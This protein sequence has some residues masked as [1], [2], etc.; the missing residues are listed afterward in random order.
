M[1][2]KIIAFSL[3]CLVALP[4]WAKDNVRTG[5]AYVN[6]TSDTANAAKSIALTEARRQIIFDVLSPY[7]DSTSLKDFL[8]FS[9]DERL[10][11]LISSTKIEGEK[12]SATSYSANIYMG[13]NLAIAKNWLNDNYIYNW[14]TLDDS[15]NTN[16]DK[17]MIFVDIDN[18]YEWLDFNNSARES[19]VAFDLSR[20]FDDS[21]SIMVAVDETPVLLT[22]L[23]N[24]GWKYSKTNDIIR[25]W[26]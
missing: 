17:S 16:V 5:T 20:I 15:N 13:V 8:A 11:N 18:L 2:K 6:I 1:I 19:G 4:V 22:A 3:V 25:V 14:I 12:L 9:T 21:A 24:F 23:E 7:A 10:M 26:K